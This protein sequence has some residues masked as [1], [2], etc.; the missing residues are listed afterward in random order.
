MRGLLDDLLNT[1]KAECPVPY[2]IDMDWP[3]RK[4]PP[5]GMTWIDNAEMPVSQV[6]A[7]REWMVRMWGHAERWTGTKGNTEQFTGNRWRHTV[8]GEVL[9]TV[10]YPPGLDP[11]AYANEC[12]ARGFVLAKPPE[13]AITSPF[14]DD[15]ELEAPPGDPAYVP[16]SSPPPGTE[17]VVIDDPDSPGRKVRMVVPPGQGEKKV[18]GGE[19]VVTAGFPWWGWALAG[20]AILGGVVF[21]RTRKPGKKAKGTY[22]RKAKRGRRG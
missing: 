2:Y 13:G 8:T 20:A 19:Q 18:P 6:G 5:A 16:P 9:W 22:Q 7:C 21:S 14:Y 11:V 4:E 3:L 15:P 12:H 10:H 17:I 1:V